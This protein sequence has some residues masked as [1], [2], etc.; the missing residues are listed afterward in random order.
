M[1]WLSWGHTKRTEEG[2]VPGAFGIDSL[3]VHYEAFNRGGEGGIVW[4][5]A[6]EV[7][8]EDY[9]VDSVDN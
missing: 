2:E 4:S 5:G 3:D 1:L 9:G 6:G 8:V 7:V